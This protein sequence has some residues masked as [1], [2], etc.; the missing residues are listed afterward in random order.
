[1]LA[2]QRIRLQP[3]VYAP[4]PTPFKD[5]TE[6]IDIAAFD[7]TVSRIG[8]AGAGILVGGTLGEGPMLAC[9]ERVAL[10]RRA[11]ASL[12]DAGLQD[13]IPVIAG[14]VGASVR[15]CIA[16]A[17]DAASAGADAVIVVASAYFAFVYGKDK[18]AVASFFTS[19]A[20]ESPLPVLIYNIPFAAG[21]I[22]LDAQI[23]MK[24]SEHQNI[25]YVCA[26][27]PTPHYIGYR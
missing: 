9:D 26:R 1:M 2:Q 18:A 25:V 17:E 10:I 27:L 3:G 23:L 24:L 12:R 21:G 15:E 8:K 11:K 19:V 6:E 4:V 22:D 5:G 16:Q 14:A 13:K 7:S 20:D